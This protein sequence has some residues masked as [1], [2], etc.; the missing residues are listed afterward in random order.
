VT[1]SGKDFQPHADNHGVSFN[2][3]TGTV[4]TVSE[5]QMQVQV[6]D[7]ATT[8]P[9]K[10][11]VGNQTAEGPGFTV[12]EKA[13][14]ISS[15]EPDSA[16]MGAKVTIKGMNFSAMSSEN[17]ITFNGTKA[18]VNSA[19]ESKLVTKVPQGATDGPIKVTVKQKTTTGPD[20]NVI[21]D[22]ILKT[23][24]TTSGSGTDPNGYKLTIDGSNNTAVDTADTVF[25]RGL[26]QGT[27][28]AKV[29]DIADNC[30]IASENPRTVNISAGDTTSTTFGVTCKAVA[31][32]KI[33]FESDRYQGTYKLVIMNADGS[34][35]HQLTAVTNN[36]IFEYNPAISHDGSKVV[37]TSN[38]GQYDGLNIV[39]IDGSDEETYAKTGAFRKPSWSPDDSKLVY[40]HNLDGNQDI[41]VYTLSAYDYTQLT[42]NS[43]DDQHPT[44]SSNGNKIAFQS[45]RDGDD[46][47][48]TMD[49][50]GDNLKKITDNTDSDE[51][52]RWS[53]AG[54]K[55]AFSSDRSG[56][57]EIYTINADGTGLAQVTNNSHYDSSPSW[58][59]DGTQIVFESKRDGDFEIYK[60]NADGSGGV[61]QLT[62]NTYFDGSPF[63]SP[64]K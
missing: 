12:E 24:I 21:T 27:H 19:S 40:G 50:N 25:T 9:V 49:T 18:S 42:T 5:D 52:P 63:W 14:G 10:V 31:H 35:K 54:N 22:G 51:Y 45:Y 55:I 47:I 6:P 3:T 4:F 53:P 48:Y 58:S 36:N 32:N 39:N 15:V 64:L 29:T 8:G 46:E 60:M 56:N 28:D 17:T 44:W 30:S 41:F 23:I 11:T 13:P 2:G 43:E 57:Y 61:V 37:F 26:E 38:W 20:F 34:D 62:N 59:P 7:S 33:V 1:I 16:T